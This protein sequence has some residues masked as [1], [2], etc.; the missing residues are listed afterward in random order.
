MKY[1]AV[2]CNNAVIVSES[3]MQKVHH[4]SQAGQI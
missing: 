3:R 2:E 1:D 4:I